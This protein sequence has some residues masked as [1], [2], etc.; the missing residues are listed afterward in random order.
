MI[1]QIK[2]DYY[3]KVGSKYVKVHLKLDEK[4]EISIIPTKEKLENHKDLKVKPIDFMKEKDMLARSIR[5]KSYGDKN[6]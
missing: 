3:I 2:S 5:V 1:Y 6:S 4:G